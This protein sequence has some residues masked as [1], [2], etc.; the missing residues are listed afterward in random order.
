ME[1]G[2]TGIIGS[3]METKWLKELSEVNGRL[4]EA[5]TLQEYLDVLGD[6]RKW[7]SLAFNL[8]RFVWRRF[9]DTAVETPTGWQVTFEGKTYRFSPV[10][11]FDDIP[12][13]E[14]RRYAELLYRLTLKNRAFDRL[15]DGTRNEKAGVISKQQYLNYLSGQRPYRGRYLS[16]SWLWGL[17][18]TMWRIS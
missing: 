13:V 2:I 7:N 5:E 4:A 14:K 8:R 10:T 15:K 11:A 1:T 6:S 3:S 9:A 18:G 17:T 12:E 16:L